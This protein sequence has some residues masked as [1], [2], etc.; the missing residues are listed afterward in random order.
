MAE[1]QRLLADGLWLVGNYEGWL[2]AKLCA[3]F[4]AVQ[5]W[6]ETKVEQ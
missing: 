6:I 3:R 4:Y 5:A 1:A 2:W